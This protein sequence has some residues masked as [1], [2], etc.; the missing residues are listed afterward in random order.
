MDIKHGV[1]AILNTE[2][3]IVG[4]GFVAAG[5]FVFI[6]AHILG[7]WAACDKSFCPAEK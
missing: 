1:V 2:D 7:Y 5:R 3:E 4:T 6:G